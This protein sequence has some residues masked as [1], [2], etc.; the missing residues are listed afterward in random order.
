MKEKVLQIKNL[1]EVAECETVEKKFLHDVINGVMNVTMKIGKD[2]IDENS[3]RQYFS[4]ALAFCSLES[5]TVKVSEK[6]VYRTTPKKDGDESQKQSEPKPAITIVSKKVSDWS[7]VRGLLV[8][9]LWR[10]NND[11]LT[12]M[13]EAVRDEGAEPEESAFALFDMSDMANFEL[14]VPGDVSGERRD[15]ILAFIEGYANAEN[16]KVPLTNFLAANFGPG[17][18]KARRVPMSPLYRSLRDS[19]SLA[20]SNS[21]DDGVD[22][23]DEHAIALACELFFKEFRF[24]FQHFSFLSE[25]AAKL[26]T[27]LKVDHHSKGFFHN[28]TEL[29]VFVI[30]RFHMLVAG[31]S[32]IASGPT[33]LTPTDMSG[34]EP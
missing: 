9:E 18:T 24:D 1:K 4:H 33:R 25:A 16:F 17:G 23:T 14:D 6:T 22:I 5:L 27:E 12:S 28:L 31:L 11:K 21:M 20:A 10:S 13:V 34:D 19:I 15:A 26:A 3:A 8:K 30:F 2:K 7:K 32:T 29:Q